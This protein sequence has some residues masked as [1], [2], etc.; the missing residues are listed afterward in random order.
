VDRLVRCAARGGDKESGQVIAAGGGNLIAAGAG[1]VIASG[2]GMYQI[3]DSVGN[4]IAAGG[5]NVIAAGGGNLNLLGGGLASL[6]NG[7]L[8][9]LSNLVSGTSQGLLQ[10]KLAFA[11]P[12]SPG[13][14]AA[15]ASAAGRGRA[16]TFGS[17]RVAFKRS[18]QRRV[19]T[20]K[21]NRRGQALLAK[22]AKSNRA[23]KKAGKRPVKLR[24]TFTNTF[25][26]RKGKAI[27]ARRSFSVAPDTTR[28]RG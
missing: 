20:V 9:N 12:P 11:A 3:L 4:V 15:S 22:T 26:P 7:T 27:T 10:S 25:K 1:Q 5:G 24:L 8:E 18:G 19:L 21:I 28:K 14:A 13:A 23:R 17:G 2:A 16:V 6:S